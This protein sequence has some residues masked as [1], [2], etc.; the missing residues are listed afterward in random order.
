MFAMWDSFFLFFCFSTLWSKLCGT[1]RDNIIDKVFVHSFFVK[2]C[3]LF[4]VY[5]TIKLSNTSVFSVVFLSDLAHRIWMLSLFEFKYYIFSIQFY[6]GNELLYIWCRNIFSNTFCC[7][8]FIYCTLAYIWHMF[9]Y[10]RRVWYTT[11]ENFL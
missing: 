6:H 1:K 10:T 9:G 8:L 5:F 3:R 4:P 2:K 11:E 7:S